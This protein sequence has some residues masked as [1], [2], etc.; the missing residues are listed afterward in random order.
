[1]EVGSLE[2]IMHDFRFFRVTTAKTSESHYYYTIIIIFNSR[3]LV[4]VDVIA[5]ARELSYEGECN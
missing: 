2:M 1:M 3:P 4:V 5:S